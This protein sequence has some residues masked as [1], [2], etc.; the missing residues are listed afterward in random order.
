MT[1]ITPSGIFKRVVGSW[2]GICA[3][4]GLSLS[5][6]VLGLGI[7][8]RPAKA[9]LFMQLF[10]IVIYTSVVRGF[11]ATL[12][13]HRSAKKLGAVVPP[14]FYF[15]PRPEDRDELRLWRWGRQFGYAMM[16]VIICMG[17][18]TLIMW[19]RGECC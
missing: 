6:V 17:G 3:I 16:T 15:G 2:V 18:F 1:E 19:L 5:L 8:F 7:R 9:P 14:G 11:V 12:G 13:L 4:L 10:P